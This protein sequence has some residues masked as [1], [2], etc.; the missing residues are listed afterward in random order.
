MSQ[1]ILCFGGDSSI[2]L[3]L[4]NKSMAVLG[5][6]KVLQVPLHRDVPQMVRAVH[7]KVDQT[8][9]DNPIGWSVNNVGYIISRHL[10][11][12]YQ[13]PALAFPWVQ[14]PQC[15]TTLV[16]G[17]D[18]AWHMIELNEPLRAII[19]PD[20][21]FHDMDGM[22]SVVTVVTEGE[23][24]PALMGF[25]FEGESADDDVALERIQVMQF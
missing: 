20:S 25:K 23:K 13:D 14:G 10:S 5:H 2:P 9:V 11:D 3:Q 24:L 21:K 18:N 6:I 17:D 19:H 12:S 16:K 8:L 22:R 7:A 15:R 4:Q 1:P